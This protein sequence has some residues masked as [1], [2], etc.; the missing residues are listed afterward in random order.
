MCL[1]GEWACLSFWCGRVYR[2]RGCVYWVSGV[3]KMFMGVTVWV[4]LM[5][6]AGAGVTFD[7]IVIFGC[8][9]PVICISAYVGMCVLRASAKH[10]KRIQE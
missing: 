4:D 7:H 5:M 10:G 1:L 6:H 2:L 3:A 9:W 8:I